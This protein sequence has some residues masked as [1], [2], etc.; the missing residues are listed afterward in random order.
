MLAVL[1]LLPAA[2]A[3]FGLRH[4]KSS[5]RFLAGRMALMVLLLFASATAFTG[6]SGGT[7]NSY[8]T[9]KGTTNITVSGTISTGN[10]NP[11]PAAT[12]TLQLIV[13]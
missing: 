10:V 7:S 5:R 8:L 4:R 13:N 11:P 3:G 12:I 2:L 9:P 6:C 1:F